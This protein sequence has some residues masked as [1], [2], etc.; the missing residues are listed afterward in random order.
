[1]SVGR[2]WPVAA[3]APAGIFTRMLDLLQ[4]RGVRSL[5]QVLEASEGLVEI[6][7]RQAEF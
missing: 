5:D 7:R 2:Y 3:P 4:A 6:R 1:M